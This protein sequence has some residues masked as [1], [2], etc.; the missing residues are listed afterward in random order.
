[1][2]MPGASPLVHDPTPP[3]AEARGRRRLLSAEEKETR[4][5]KREIVAIVCTFLLFVLLTV[6]ELSLGRIHTAL[7]FNDN[8][9]FFFIINVNIILILLMI[10]L[11]MRNIVK[12]VFERRRR[13]LGATLRTK[14][15]GAFLLL[16][17]VPTGIL[18]FVAW[19][20]I[21]R[22]I[23]M[24]V[25]VQ[26]ERALDGALSVSRSYYVGR[27]DEA[28]Y[29]ARQIGR[30]LEREGVLD[31]ERRPR[32]YDFL[33][34]QQM[35]YRL[36]AVLFIAPGAR[37]TVTLIS[38][39]TPEGPFPPEPAALGEVW[40]GREITRLREAGRAEII[41]AM[42]P[43]PMPGDGQE[44]SYAALV[45]QRI[46]PSGLVDKMA[47]ITQSLE[48]HQQMMLF[49][50]PFKSV[51]FMALI[52]V[53]LLIVFSA[54]WFGFY[55]AKGMT[56][57]IQRLADG[58]REV[59][60]GNL[61]QRIDIASDDEMGVLVD[62]YNRMIRDLRNSG[63]QVADAQFR[64]QQTNVELENRRRY[65]EIVLRN[66]DAGV[67]S[68]DREGTIHTINRFLEQLF[69]VKG[70][71]YL[72]RN[73]RELFAGASMRPIREFIDEV[74]ETRSRSMERQ[75][76]VTANQEPKALRVRTRVLED[77]EGT[78]VGVV[79]VFE[80]HTELI[81]A[82]RVA[83]WREVARRI[84]H[85][86][87]NPLTP[88]Q[89]SAQRL[90]KRYRHRLQDDGKIFE[91]CTGTIIRQVEEMKNLVSEFSQFARMPAA[92]LERSDLN[93]IVDQV[94]S[95][96]RQAHRSLRFVFDPA[97]DLPELMLDP[98][99]M[100]RVLNN[101]LAN[102]VDASGAAGTISIATRFEPFLRIA[103]LEIADEGSGI[104]SE[105]RERI[106]EP[107]MSGKKGGTGLGLAIVKTIVSDHNGYIRVRENDPRGTRFFLEF[108]VPVV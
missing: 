62:S 8:V 6:A 51:S 88:I 86:I 106:F 75:I 84:A 12:L 21:S 57:P 10:F 25:H 92:R 2:E 97:L 105:I 3:P 66:V 102:A 17:L 54:T 63:E 67:L 68:M 95:F 7:P 26:V 73:Y 29:F 35:A 50:V 81:R 91:D 13:V 22:S 44:A 11:I 90:Q 9:L 71:E 87:K 39:D 19:S 69:C 33:R 79:M 77:E 82:Q 41:E 37:E 4:R 52:M 27:S 30:F 32:L 40:A 16:S 80:D 15:V 98:D 55:L 76:H 49:K 24:W 83:A 59:A 65:M 70:A 23:E 28:L 36:D 42:V 46:I 94:L 107:Y 101:L 104:S 78:W 100:Q 47:Q 99:Q 31:A 18:F 43:L 72:G 85:E 56:V 45:V 60:A 103:V 34:L 89:L 58:I 14:L 5:R 74:N 1:M 53:T 64:L 61:T 108:P 48:R 20:F 38:P 96:Y 93:R